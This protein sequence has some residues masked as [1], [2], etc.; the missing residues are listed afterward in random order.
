M[1]GGFVR[2]LV[3]ARHDEKDTRR[4]FIGDGRGRH[5]D[6]HRRVTSD[7]FENKSSVF[8]AREF[9]DAKIFVR[10]AAHDNRG[11]INGTIFDATL[12]WYRDRTFDADTF[13]LAD[14]GQAD[15]DLYL[16][17]LVTGD[18]VTA[19]LSAYNTVEHIHFAL[20]ATSEYALLV[21]YYDAIF[22]EIAAIEYG[23]AWSTTVVPEPTSVMLFIIAVSAA[24]GTPL[25]LRRKGVV[26]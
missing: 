15:R 5:D 11:S 17:D 13:D 2:N 20:P 3:I 16:I 24:G 19:S 14:L 10:C 21:D 12:T 8:H 25:R 7:R 6:R 9:F 4:I 18:F 23:L 22:G 1:E 26:E